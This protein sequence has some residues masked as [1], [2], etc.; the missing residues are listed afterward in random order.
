MKKLQ[1]LMA[2]ILVFSSGATAQ[3]GA[4]GGPKDDIHN[5]KARSVDVFRVTFRAH[6]LAAIAVRG[7]GDS[8]LDL[9]VYDENGNLIACD[10]DPTDQ[11]LV[12]LVPQWTG[13]FVIRVVNR[14]FVSNTYRIGTN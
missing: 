6:E 5:V 10:T 4:V 12:T 14:G 9:Y 2:A 7:D 3:A 13:Q 8:D 11:C 1:G